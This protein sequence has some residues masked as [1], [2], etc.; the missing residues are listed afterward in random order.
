[1]HKQYKHPPNI[2]DIE[3][4]STMQTSAPARPPTAA[5]VGPATPFLAEH[6]LAAAAAAAAALTFIGACDIANGELN[7]N[8]WLR[9]A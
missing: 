8:S 2:F 9:C 1:L 4:N 6:F 7:R 5:A 3:L